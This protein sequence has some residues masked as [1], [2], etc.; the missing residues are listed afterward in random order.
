MNKGILRSI[1]IFT[2]IALILV[3]IVIGGVRFVKDR[4]NQYT[5]N[6]VPP[7][8]TLN[9]TQ[10]QQ[11]PTSSQ[12]QPQQRS[13]SPQTAPQTKPEQTAPSSSIPQQPSPN[14]TNAPSEVPVTGPAEDMILTIVFMMCAAY[15][16]LVLKRARASYRRLLY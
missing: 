8:T 7:A 13:P 16:G 10:G 11:A 15:F 4:N 9:T 5:A 3:A 2:A 14:A 1:G 12:N 6:N